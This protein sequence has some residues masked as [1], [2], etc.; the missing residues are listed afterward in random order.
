MDEMEN[1]NPGEVTPLS[2]SAYF[3]DTHRKYLKLVGGDEETGS[4][5]YQVEYKINIF[6]WMELINCIGSYT[7]NC[8]VRLD[9]LSIA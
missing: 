9:I 7:T 4:Q 8:S 2:V 6:Q 3:D 5:S 1:E